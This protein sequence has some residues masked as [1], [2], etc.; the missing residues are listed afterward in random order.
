MGFYQGEVA[1]LRLGEEFHHNR[2]DLFCS[3]ISG[4]DPAAQHRWGKPRLW[5]T[6]VDL[7]QRGVLDLLPLITHTAR[8]DDAP[9]MFERL[10]RGEPGLLQAT[11]SF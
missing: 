9:A 6:A 8:F 5:R 11:L 7:Q 10:D 4:T 2:V 1:G 3:Q